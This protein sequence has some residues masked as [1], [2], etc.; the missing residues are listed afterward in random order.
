M[1]IDDILKHGQKEYPNEACGLVII[2]K[3]KEKYI[4]CENNATNPSEDFMIS[5][6]DYAKAE[7]I[8]TVIKIAHT[9]PHTAPKPTQADLIEIENHGLP[10]IIANPTTKEWQEY[11]PKGYTPDLLGRS[12]KHGIVDC[13]TL[14]KDYYKVKLGI[15]LMDIPDREEKWWEKGYNLYERN[16]AKFGFIRVPTNSPILLHDVF[17]MTLHSSI[18][19]H[20]AVYIGE[21]KIMHHVEGR[22]SSIDTYGGY[23]QK[24]TWGRFRYEGL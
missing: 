2:F 8:G 6:L 10:W 9:H 17:L 23:W 12:F 24:A 16:Y 18:P 5:P 7:D 19:N 1:I 20:A 15:E 4:P 21:G 22:L 11:S 13:Y 3:G 14:I